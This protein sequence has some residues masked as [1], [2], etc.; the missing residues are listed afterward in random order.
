VDPAWAVSDISCTPAPLGLEE[1]AFHPTWEEGDV[2][3]LERVGE[4][5]ESERP[6]LGALSRVTLSV[7]EV[8]SDGVVLTWSEGVPNLLFDAAE[9]TVREYLAELDPLRYDY[10]INALREYEGAIDIT[11]IR[12]WLSDAAAL[13]TAFGLDLEL[14]GF[15]QVMA[16]TDEDLESLWTQEP[17]N[18][19]RLDGMTVAVGEEKA[20][21]GSIVSLHTSSEVSAQTTLRIVDLVDEDGCITVE[22]VSRPDQ[23]GLFDI[24]SEYLAFLG[25]E[26]SEDEIREDLERFAVEN[27]YIGQ[28]DYL[29]HRFIRVVRVDYFSN[30][31]GERT[32]TVTYT[33]VTPEG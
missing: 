13:A 18:F 11:Q 10:R 29:E 22:L 15:E 9:P 8:T 31:G 3:Q 5:S 20:G 32:Q 4:V 2:H 24:V 33:D 19:H 27:R 1:L 25:I 30:G 23:A 7:S 14:S 28:W 17:A 21:E 16:M 6:T 26:R 12:D